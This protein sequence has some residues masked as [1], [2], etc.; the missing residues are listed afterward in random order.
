M[1][2]N[3]K[4]RS[5]STHTGPSPSSAAMFQMSVGAFVTSA[6][7]RID[8]IFVTGHQPRIVGR[9][10]GDERGNVL[11]GQPPTD[12]LRLDDLGLAFR[13]VPFHLPRCLDIAGD[14]AIDADVVA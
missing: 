4:A 9:Q 2:T 3:H 10:E 7:P 13:R 1:S 12:A 8:E 11:R 6:P 5:R 14:H